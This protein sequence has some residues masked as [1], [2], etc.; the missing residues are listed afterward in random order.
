M[1]LQA[2]LA[3]LSQQAMDCECNVS[4]RP[5][6]QRPELPQRALA[7]EA[8]PLRPP[9]ASLRRSQVLL[10]LCTRGAGSRWH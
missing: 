10:K 8:A 6:R 5:A 2:Q 7:R 1:E 3:Q 4:I 9:S